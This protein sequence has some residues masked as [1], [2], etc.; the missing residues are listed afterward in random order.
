MWRILE[1][2]GGED[3]LGQARKLA[4][5]HV[6]EAAV[7]RLSRI[8]DLA[9]DAGFG[10]H[11][12]FDFG[13]MQDLDYYSG[14]ILEAYA[15]GV[16]LP[17]ATGGRYD[18][19]LARFDWDIPGVGFAVAVDRAA[20]AL[21]EAGVEFAGAPAAIPF[22]GGLEAPAR[23]AE[24]RRA[25]LAVAALPED[26]AGVEPPLVLRRGGGYTLRLA[27]GREVSGDAADIAEALRS[28]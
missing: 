24:L 12:A 4:R 2:S 18:G 9:E 28:G 17:L 10:D 7:A 8:R 1:L 14:L 23:A 11:L 22:I 3:V 20:D 5:N 15:P 16:G 13:L 21:D 26:A 19:L 6:M 25:G 27:G